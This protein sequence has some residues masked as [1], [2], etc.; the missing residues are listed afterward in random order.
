MKNS[1]FRASGMPRVLLSFSAILLALALII[2]VFVFALD[3]D[4]AEPLAVSEPQTPVE[5]DTTDPASASLT[6][7]QQPA[8]TTASANVL[9]LADGAE[10]TV[11]TAQKTVAAVL[12][13]AD[14]TLEELDEISPDGE[15]PVYDGMRI[16]VTRVRNVQFETEIEIEC[17][18]EKQYNDKL[19]IGETK[20]LVE[21][22]NGVK[23]MVFEQTLRDGVMVEN[24]ILASE[25]LS[26]PV[27]RVISVGTKPIPVTTVATTKKT[28]VKTTQ[29]TTQKTTKKTTAKPTTKPSTVVSEPEAITVTA[30]GKTYDVSRLIKGESVAYYSNRTNPSTA[31]GNPAI[32]GKTI[33]VDP[34][35]I[36]LGSLVYITSVDG[37]SWSYGPAYA[38]DVGGGIKGNIVDLFKASYSECVAHGRRNC[39]IYI[40]KP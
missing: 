4:P 37:K 36:P 17:D 7:Y 32:P 28:T 31:T 21:G 6:A 29:K 24:R 34:K 9:I 8:E 1:A 35:V 25:I 11:E 33:A 2:S 30:G 13:E 5:N 14:I 23:K 19:Y 12:K 22:R 10:K 16:T 39:I 15:N 18:T 3:D 40:L 38:H 20:T 26:E 27:T